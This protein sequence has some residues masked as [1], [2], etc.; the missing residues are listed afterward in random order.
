MRGAGVAWG[1]KKPPHG[2][3]A[4]LTWRTLP[5]DSDTVLVWPSIRTAIRPTY[6]E[7]HDWLD[8]RLETAV[9][10]GGGDEAR[11]SDPGAGGEVLGE[12]AEAH[13]IRA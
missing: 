7:R 4:N 6:G 13:C 10:V 5:Q 3:G 12:L 9:E 11:D 8:G 1:G 2:H